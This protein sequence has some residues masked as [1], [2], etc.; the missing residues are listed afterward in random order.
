MP[1]RARKPTRTHEFSRTSQ[2]NCPSR[3]AKRPVARVEVFEQILGGEIFEP[4]IL[5]PFGL[6]LAAVPIEEIG[7]EPA[8]GLEGR[9]LRGV[10]Q[11]AERRDRSMTKA[12]DNGLADWTPRQV[13]LDSRDDDL[14]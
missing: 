14:S 2:G 7:E 8:A 9:A 10:E 11:Q 13:S 1:V 3:D 4:V 5:P 12:A 6:H